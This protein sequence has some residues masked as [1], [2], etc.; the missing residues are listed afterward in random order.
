MAITV[1]SVE[2]TFDVG[3]DE[4]L[5]VKQLKFSINNQ[6]EFFLDPDEA[7]QVIN[8][9]EGALYDMEYFNETLKDLE[10]LF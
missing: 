1:E 9:I 8:A 3:A 5:T 7:E 4:P 6:S 2:K 10:S